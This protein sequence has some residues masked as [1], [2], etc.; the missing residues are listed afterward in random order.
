MSWQGGRGCRS[1]V[2]TQIFIAHSCRSSP[3]K[4]QL[5]MPP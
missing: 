5:T 4:F 2:S 3:V 1:P